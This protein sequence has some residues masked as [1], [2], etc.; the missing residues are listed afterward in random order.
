MIVILAISLLLLM[1]PIWMHFALVAAW[2]P[3]GDPSFGLALSDKTVWEIFVGPGTFSA[4]GADEAGH[5]R[6]V[7][8]VFWG[9]MVLAMA[10]LGLILWRVLRHG[11]EA[12]TWRSMSRGGVA[13]AVILVIAGPLALLFFDSAFE[14]FHRIFFPGGNFSFP[15]DSLLIIL[16]PFAFWQISASALGALGVIGGLFIWFFARRRARALEAA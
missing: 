16:Y 3:G 15:P 8:F 12:R 14:L 2:A 11:H 13:L 1:T 7:R 4:F 10:S 6:D 9:F 5:M